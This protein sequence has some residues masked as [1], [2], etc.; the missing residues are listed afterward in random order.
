MPAASHHDT[1]LI[2]EKCSNIMSGLHAIHNE[3]NKPGLDVD[4]I[5]SHNLDVVHVLEFLQSDLQKS[6]LV[7][8][9]LVHSNAL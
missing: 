7:F 2:V 8:L 5:C 4:I 9:D 3:C 6:S 1:I